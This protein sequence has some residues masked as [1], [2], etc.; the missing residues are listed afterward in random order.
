MSGDTLDNVL[1]T[2]SGLG[3]EYGALRALDGVSLTVHA[4]ELAIMV[5]RNGAGKST[6]L[7]CLAGWLR[8]SDGEVRIFGISAT[9]SE[10]ALRRH[11]LLVPDAPTFYDELTAWEHLQFVAQAHRLPNWQ[12]RADALL[13]HL[14]LRSGRDAYPFTFSRGMRYKLALC[15][16]LLVQP[17]LLLLDEPLGPLDPLSVECLWQEL[18]CCRSQGTGILLSSHQLPEI[19]PDRYLVLEEGHLVAAGTLR[20]LG[21]VPGATGRAALGKLLRSALADH[22]DANDDA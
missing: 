14:G 17:R 22:G 5:G 20:E 8:P 15:L 18:E 1:L 4:G 21:V 3:Y 16:A 12:E 13:Q 10:R 6:L 7:R 2:A 9:T 19:V 11:V